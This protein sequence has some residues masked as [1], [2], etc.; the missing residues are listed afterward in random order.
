MKKGTDSGEAKHSEPPRAIGLFAGIGGIEL[1]LS[2][3]GFVSELLCENDTACQA[4]LSKR[5][6]EVKLVADVRDLR[7]IPKVDVLA[8]GFPCQDLSQAG[9]TMGMSGLRSSLVYEVLRLVERRSTC[10][11]FLLLENVPFML[12]LRKGEAM[13]VLVGTLEGLG[14]SW[15]YRVV[16]SRS[17]GLPQRRQRVFLLASRTEDPR[18]VLFADEA[19]EDLAFRCPKAYGFFWTEGLRGLGWA[20]D[21]V[22]TLKGGSGLGIPSPPAIWLPSRDFVGT[23]G[24]RDVERLQG[25]PADW[26]DVDC[27]TPRQSRSRWRMVGNAVSVPVA[28]WIGERLQCPG[29]PLGTQ[30]PLPK[31]DPWPRAACGSGGQRFAVD[32]SVFP[33]TAAFKPITDFLED[34]LQPLSE[35]AVKGFLERAERSSLRFHPVFLPSLRQYIESRYSLAVS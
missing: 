21:S 25:F 30:R 11:R 20:E 10:P 22:P 5:F 28:N 15:A 14:F 23:P 26:T 31:G 27:L 6:P 24:I 3:S 1:G 33:R 34:D 35:R 9:L 8:A 2:Q 18:T 13:N 7:S 32:L 19:S 4:V 12:S 17:F 29:P 16:D